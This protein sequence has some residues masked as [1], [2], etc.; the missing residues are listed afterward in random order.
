VRCGPHENSFESA[1]PFSNW[2]REITLFRSVPRH[3]VGTLEQLPLS[4]DD[5]DETEPIKEG[6]D[7]PGFPF[8][9]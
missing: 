1:L 5:E 7:G 2:W 6:C 4:L 3:E 8:E 9:E